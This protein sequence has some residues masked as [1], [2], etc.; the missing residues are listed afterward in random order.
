MECQKIKCHACQKEISVGRYAAH[1]ENGCKD[2][3]AVAEPADEDGSQGAEEQKQDE[4]VEAYDQD[5]KEESPAGAS[6]DDRWEEEP[7]AEIEEDKGSEY[8]HCE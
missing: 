7:E 3:S 2:D 4:P 8:V 1:I 5:L 6:Y